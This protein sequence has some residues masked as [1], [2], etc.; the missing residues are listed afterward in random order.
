MPF[1]VGHKKIEGSGMKKE[2]TIKRGL[3][4][5][6]IAE[7]HNVC[8]ITF[9]CNVINDKYP[10]ADFDHKMAAVKELAPYLFPK[11]KQIEH[12]GEGGT[13]LFAKLLNKVNGSSNT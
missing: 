9:L 11:L 12:T 5:L 2:Q 6:K 4:A 3:A 13:D 8:P 10:E 7:E 1:E